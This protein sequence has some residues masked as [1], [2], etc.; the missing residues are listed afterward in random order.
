[1]FALGP[2]VFVINVVWYPRQVT[3]ELGAMSVKRHI[4][5]KGLA[6]K[7]NGKVFVR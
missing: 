7:V 1:M 3:S 4:N 2:D 5:L 6:K